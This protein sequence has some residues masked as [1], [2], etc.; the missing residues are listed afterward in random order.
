MNAYSIQSSFNKLIL[1]NLPTGIGTDPV[2]VV[3]SMP[4]VTDDL[5][6]FHIS[7]AYEL[8]QVRPTR[9]LVGSWVMT[10]TAMPYRA[11]PTW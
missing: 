1:D 11:R 7:L 9:R 3:F 8:Q 4:D 2:K 5:T 10:T 6:G